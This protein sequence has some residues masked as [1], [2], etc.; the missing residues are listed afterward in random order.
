MGTK[1]KLIKRF[2]SNPKDFTFEEFVRLF[3]IFGYEQSNKGTTSGSR[4]EFTNGE[5]SFMM[6]KPHPKNIIKSYVM[7][8]ALSAYRTEIKYPKYNSKAPYAAT[9][10]D[11][12]VENQIDP[13][14]MSIRRIGGK[15]YCIYWDN[16]VEGA[17]IKSG[18]GI[19]EYNLSTRV[20]SLGSM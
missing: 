3:A 9:V 11:V 13:S 18:T 2:L 4:I 1:N 10:S 15:E 16:L 19:T 8:E 6:H 12:L 20:A 17:Y 7:K 14:V 5:N